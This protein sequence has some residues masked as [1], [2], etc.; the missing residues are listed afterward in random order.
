MTLNINTCI[1]CGKQ[2]ENIVRIPYWRCRDCEDK[3][4]ECD[5]Y[6]RNGEKNYCKKCMERYQNFVMCL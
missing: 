2:E 1:T 5:S 3:C 6:L 4:I